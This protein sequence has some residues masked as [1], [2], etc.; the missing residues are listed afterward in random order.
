MGAAYLIFCLAVAVA[1]AFVMTI[2]QW[3]KAE[4]DLAARH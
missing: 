2:H 3:L 1:T 4:S